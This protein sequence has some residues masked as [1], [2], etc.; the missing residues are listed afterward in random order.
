[1]Q[2]PPR[3]LGITVE[4]AAQSTKRRTIDRG[5]TSGRDFEVL[6]EKGS[7]KKVEGK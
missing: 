2:R 6:S 7:N 3:R 1:M 5:R 4:D